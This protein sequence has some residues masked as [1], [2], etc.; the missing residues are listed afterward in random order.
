MPLDP[1]TRLGPYE[2][3]GPIGAGVMSVEVSTGDGLSLS[4]PVAIVIGWDAE[5]R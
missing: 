2:I 3:S 5:L 4:T 1:G